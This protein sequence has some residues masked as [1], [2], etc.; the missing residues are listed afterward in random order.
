MSHRGN[1]ARCGVAA[2][3]ALAYSTVVAAGVSDQRPT[4]TAPRSAYLRRMAAAHP[5]GSPWRVD[6][7]GK[8]PASEGNSP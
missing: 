6:G 5:D 3:S 4:E 1:Y 7:P 8:D 2:T